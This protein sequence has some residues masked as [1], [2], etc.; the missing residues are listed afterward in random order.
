MFTVTDLKQMAYCPRIPYF[1]YCLPGLRVFPTYKM[2]AGAEANTAEEARE[3]RRGLRAY[4]LDGDQ[5]QATRAFGVSLG[6]ETVGVNGVVDMLITVTDGGRVVE[7]IPVDYKN[8]DLGAAGPIRAQ[9]KLRRNWL[10]QL[11]AYALLVEDA[12]PADPPVRRGF[13]YSI[14]MRRAFQADLHDGLRQDTRALVE[15]LR[16]MTEGERM[17]EATSWRQR[18]AACEYRRYCNDI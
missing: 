6:S 5:A 14:P 8:A 3:D 15:A 17:P 13:I 12:W 11:T 10:I 16:L 7:R 18:C 9:A 1:Q 2:E 4:G